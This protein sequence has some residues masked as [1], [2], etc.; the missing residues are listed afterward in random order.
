MRQL[1]DGKGSAEIEALSPGAM[2]GYAELCAWTLA[3][4]H[5]RSGDRAAIAAYLGK[6][7]T[8]DQAIADFAVAYGDQ[9]EDDYRRMRE[10]EAAGSLNV[11]RGV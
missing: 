4:G 1:W 7:E 3:R 8:F 9:N 11:A 6:G 10:A 5:A 2:E